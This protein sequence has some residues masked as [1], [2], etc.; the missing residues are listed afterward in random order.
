MRHAAEAAHK[1]TGGGDD[2]LPADEIAV[3]GRLKVDSAGTPDWV[4][5]DDWDADRL[6]VVKEFGDRRPLMRRRLDVGETTWPAVSKTCVQ[7]SYNLRALAHTPTPRGTT[8]LKFE[9]VDIKISAEPLSTAEIDFKSEAPPPLEIPTYYSDL[10]E[11]LA[12]SPVPSPVSSP[13][14]PVFTSDLK[15]EYLKSD[16]LKPDF[17]KPGCVK[18]SPSLLPVLTPPLLSSPTGGGS[19][20]LPTPLVTPLTPP[21]PPPPRPTTLSQPTSSQTTLSQATSSQTASSQPTSSQTTPVQSKPVEFG[22]AVGRYAQKAPRQSKLVMPKVIRRYSGCSSRLERGSGRVFGR[23]FK[24][25]K[26]SHDSSSKE[27]RSPRSSQSYTPPPPPPLSGS[28]SQGLPASGN[29]SKGLPASGNASQGLSASGNTSQ[30]LPA[31]GN[32]SKGLPASGIRKVGR[33]RKRKFQTSR[34]L[35][36]RELFYVRTGLRRLA[37]HRVLGRKA[38]TC[39]HKELAESRYRFLKRRCRPGFSTSASHLQPLVPPGCG[40]NSAETFQPPTAH[41]P[42]PLEGFQPFTMQSVETPPS[43][44]FSS[45]THMGSPPA[46]PDGSITS[47]SLP[48]NFGRP[49]RPP[50]LTPLPLSPGQCSSRQPSLQCPTPL[51]PQLP[52]L[53]RFQPLSHGIQPHSLS[54]GIQPLAPGQP[55]PRRGQPLPMPYVSPPPPPS[56]SAP[57]R[58][59]VASRG[60]RVEAP[61]VISRG[62]RRYARQRPFTCPYCSLRLK[63]RRLLVS[64]VLI[65]PL[66]VHKCAPISVNPPPRLDRACRRVYVTCGFATQYV[67]TCVRIKGGGPDVGLLHDSGDDFEPNS[68]DTESVGDESDMDLALEMEFG[69]VGGKTPAKRLHVRSPPA[70]RLH[71]RSP[72]AKPLH[73]RSQPAKRGRAVRGRKMGVRGRRKRERM[74][75]DLE[76]CGVVEHSDIPWVP[77]PSGTKFKRSPLIVTIPM[78]GRPR[79]KIRGRPRGSLRGRNNRRGRVPAP[80]IAG[81]LQTPR[82]LVDSNFLTINSRTL[83]SP[84]KSNGDSSE[85]PM[86]LSTD[87]KFPSNANRLPSG[88]VSHLISANMNTT[89]LEDV[90]SNCKIR[91][92]SVVFEDFSRCFV[93][94]AMFPRPQVLSRRYLLSP[95]PRRVTR[96]MRTPAVFPAD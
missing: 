15:P 32:T 95:Q 53:S 46:S 6:W 24:R 1:Q 28:T 55:V 37:V 47:T 33:K 25:I 76:R 49:P 19:S 87:V 40:C 43:S 70:K 51:N 22:T 84:I 27:N 12:A 92:V 80:C 59:R 54:F 94:R 5:D 3:G 71:V 39:F 52:F 85:K 61:P 72:Q 83:P 8:K 82:V 66:P 48:F 36:R 60:G 90:N 9:S 26:N 10:I 50:Q 29:T 20:R 81:D 35:T 68:S 34:Q 78:R 74:L 88:N 93:G 45:S 2:L 86:I 79:G 38:G 16:Y 96:S 30:G 44:P 57:V 31:S 14:L 77:S 41:E 67:G 64:H 91:R 18:Q 65:H 13:S 23:L 4:A 42:G 75:L 7:S 73:V 69:Y 58:L 56:H 89:C 63:S 17:I 62:S 21:P 11:P